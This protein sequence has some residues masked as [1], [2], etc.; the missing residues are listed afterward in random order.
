MSEA[1][2]ADNYKLA[3]TTIENTLSRVKEIY[4]NCKEDDDI[5]NLINEL[6]NY[7][8]ALSKIRQQKK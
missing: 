2:E 8:M 1:F 6:T 5:K 4:P 7:A 3:L